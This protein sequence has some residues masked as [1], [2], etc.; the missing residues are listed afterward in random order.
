MTRH[1]ALKPPLIYPCHTR[2]KPLPIPPTYPIPN[3]ALLPYRTPSR[4]LHRAKYA[5]QNPTRR[6]HARAAELLRRRQIEQHVCGNEGARGLV[7]EDEF[8]VEVGGHV[9]EVEFGV[10]FRRDGGDGF[11]LGEEEGEGHGFVVLFGALFG[12]CFDAE[13][14]GGGVG[15]VPGAE[16]D[17]VLG[18]GLDWVG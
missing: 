2:I 13:N 17:V 15:L 12:Q 14:L 9:F 10:E 6:I 4:T 5:R 7:V 3:R 16:E 18:K 8:F 1:N 11:G